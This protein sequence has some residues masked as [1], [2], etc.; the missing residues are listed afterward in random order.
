MPSR[1]CA[2]KA[3]GS[4]GEDVRRFRFLFLTFAVALLALAVLLVDRALHSVALERQLRHQALAERVFDE[5]ERGLSRLLER[6]EKRPFEHYGAE[7]EPTTLPF[8]IGYFQ[9]DPDGSLHAQPVLRADE[10][11][12]SD[13]PFRSA[14]QANQNVASEIERIVSA[15]GRAGQD[16]TSARPAV[17]AQIPG[18]TIQL[19]AG[20]RPAT[21]AAAPAPDEPARRDVSAFDALRALNKGVQERAERQQ[22]ALEQLSQ[23]GV[24][25]RAAVPGPDLAQYLSDAAARSEIES[26]PMSG[27]VIDSQHLLLSRSV[28]RDGQA[29]RQ[30]ML[31]DV[32][33]LGTWLRE[34]GLGSD[35][36]GL[37][38]YTDVSFVTPFSTTPAAVGASEFFYQH[39]FAEPFVDLTA[40]LA[41]RPLPGIGSDTYVYALCALLLATAVLGLAALYRMV[42]VVVSFAERRNNF[43]AA[44]SHELKTPLTAIR[45]YGEMLRDGVVPSDAKRHEY[46]RHITVESERLS[47]LI[48]NVLEFS[49]LEKGTREMAFVVGS[50]APVVQDVAELLRPH[51]HAQGFQLHFEIDADL[52]PVRFERDALM[53]VLWNLVDNALKYA[54]DASRKRVELRCWHDGGGVHVSVRDHGPGVSSRHLDKIFEPFY[55]GE[56]ELTRR[57]KGTGLGLA[58][59]RGLV[60]R[61]GARVS[62]GNVADGGFEVEIVFRPVPG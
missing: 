3:I 11:A 8:V 4:S 7:G 30:G 9:V 37:S 29:Y 39:R 32:Q 16:M 10:H 35:A 49:R 59:V 25:P 41:L 34:Q 1:P 47:R 42:S 14:R 56:S 22:K 38:A 12:A 57:S 28:V 58:L 54:H 15:H 61:M 17:G 20:A 18:T 44:V 60:E 46:Y 13:R 45:M 23:A 53:Q 43:V 5:M 62:G 19:G 50:V 31:F 2:A 40:R 55:R 48:N 21:S 6:E 52:P 26:A 51:V 36:D 24:V 27:R 33:Q